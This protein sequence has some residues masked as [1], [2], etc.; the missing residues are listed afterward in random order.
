MYDE[1]ALVPYV[2]FFYNIG[3]RSMQE[4]LFWLEMGQFVYLM[5]SFL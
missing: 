2:R 1:F 4:L 5:F 3:M